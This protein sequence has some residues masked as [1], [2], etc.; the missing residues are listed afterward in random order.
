MLDKMACDYCARPCPRQAWLH[1]QLMGYFFRGEPLPKDAWHLVHKRFRRFV[2]DR[3]R[4]GRAQLKRSKKDFGNEATK[5]I[6]LLAN[7]KIKLLRD[8]QIF[9]V[10][11]NVM[12]ANYADGHIDAVIY[13]SPN[14][15]SFHRGAEREYT[16]WTPTYRDPNDEQLGAFIDRLGEAWLKFYIAQSGDPNLPILQFPD[17]RE[18]IEALRGR[19]RRI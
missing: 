8:D 2:E 15:F 19:R 6:L 9:G 18:G 12:A 3:V 16:T 4:K 13:F 5:S 17:V 10:I 7:E 1:H 14:V 11:C